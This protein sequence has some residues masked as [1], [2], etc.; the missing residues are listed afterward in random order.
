[1]LVYTNPPGHYLNHVVKNKVPIILIPGISS[2]W[3]FMKRLGDP[4][5][6]L[7]HPV[8]IVNKLGFNLM[9]IPQSAKIVREI[10]DQNKLEKAI[11]IGHS[12]GGLMGKYFLVHEN[13]DNRIKGVIA[14][15]AP[16][17]G[18]RIVYHLNRIAYKELAPEGKM[19]K[20]LASYKKMNSKIISIMPAFDNHIWSEKK[21]YLEGATNIIFP[22]NGHHKIVFD[23]KSIRKIIELIEK[24]N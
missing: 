23:K 10:V 9:D 24:F 3:G 12:K 17:S 19:I 6:R 5:S 14:I 2:R 13:N 21:S 8:Y 7:G 20:N 1:M 11:I 4:I 15:G 18:S 22:V 16:F